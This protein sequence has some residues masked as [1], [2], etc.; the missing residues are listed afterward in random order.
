[1]EKR[2]WG[3]HDNTVVI[4]GHDFASDLSLRCVSAV[5]PDVS[6]CCVSAVWHAGGD[7]GA[8]EH[9]HHLHRWPRLPYWAVWT[10][11]GEIHAIWLWYPCAFLYSWAKCGTWIN[12]RISV[13]VTFSCRSSC[14][15]EIIWLPNSVS[16]FLLFKTT[17]GACRLVI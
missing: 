16:G 3:N 9:L 15:S 2:F 8:A 11:Q 10:G 6:L 13:F 5:W 12:V 14:T 17:K 1:M 4:S 7:G